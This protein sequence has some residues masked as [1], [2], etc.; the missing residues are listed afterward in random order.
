MF[1]SYADKAHTLPP[2]SVN[3]SPLQVHANTCLHKLV[4]LHT[5]VYTLVL[6]I[7]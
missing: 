5:M 2:Q 4:T 7:M 6:S 3:G 1:Q